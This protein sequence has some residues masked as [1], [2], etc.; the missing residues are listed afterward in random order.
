LAIKRWFIFPPYLNSV[1]ALPWKTDKHKNCIFFT[2]CY[3]Y[4]ITYQKHSV[5]RLS[6]DSFIPLLKQPT[7]DV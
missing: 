1:S 3:D 7:A 5:H 2:Q 4:F 6:V